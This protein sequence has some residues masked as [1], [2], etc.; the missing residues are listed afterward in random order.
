M[1]PID[2]K[3]FHDEAASQKAYILLRKPNPAARKYIGKPGFA[4]KPVDCRL[5]TADQDFVHLKF[6]H[7]VTAGGLVVNPTLEGFD[8]A[9]KS[10]K[11]HAAAVKLW[12]EFRSHVAETAEPN[13]NPDARH[14]IVNENPQSPFYGCIADSQISPANPGHVLHAVYDLYAYIPTPDTKTVERFLKEL[15]KQPRYPEAN[16]SDYQPRLNRR[17]GIPMIQH[18][19]HELTGQYIDDQVFVFMPDTTTVFWLANQLEIREFYRD[20]LAGRRVSRH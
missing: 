4:P 19:P 11:S 15:S 20:V 9:F 6:G 16:F 10:K 1:R 8:K 13:S 3:A 17:M 12:D 14:F 2:V 5:K 18:A 7:N